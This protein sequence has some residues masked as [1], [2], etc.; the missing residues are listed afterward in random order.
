[1]PEEIN[2][3]LT[4]Q[5][6]EFL[7]TTEASAHENLRR[8]EGLHRRRFTLEAQVCGPHDSNCNLVFERR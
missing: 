5:I 1:M 2:R 4:D 6:S 3:L 7:F 8:A